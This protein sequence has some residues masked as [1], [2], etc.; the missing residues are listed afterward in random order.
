MNLSA[1]PDDPLRTG[2][3]HE[4]PGEHYPGDVPEIDRDEA[5]AEVQAALAGEGQRAYGET[6]EWWADVLMDHV[7]NVRENVLLA[8]LD[9]GSCPSIR[10]RLADLLGDFIWATAQE[11][12]TKTSVAEAHH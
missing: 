2:S 1:I 11:L 9:D 10:A 3:P 6:A 7:S 4:A 12:V 5:V 8:L